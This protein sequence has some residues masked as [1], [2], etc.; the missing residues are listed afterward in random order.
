MKKITAVLLALWLCL[1]FTACGDTETNAEIL[2]TPTTTV[3]ATAEPTI[4]PIPE[5][6][7]TESVPTPSATPE[8][9]PKATKKPA[10]TVK[11]TTA[12]KPT[13]AISEAPKATAA[14]T[15]QPTQEALTL[16]AYIASIQAELDELTAALGTD[17][18]IFARKNSLVY[19]YQYAED[20]PDIEAMRAALEEAMETQASVFQALYTGL[21][22]DVPSLE[23]VTVEYL[24]ADGTMIYSREF[25]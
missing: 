20:I 19:S 22:G 4:S 2:P 16:E 17:I 25:N 6:A 15:P 18:K 7:Q 13:P 1:S 9:T 21:K 8:A 24:A 3:S 11:P 10:P 23:S 5:A 12:T 14:P